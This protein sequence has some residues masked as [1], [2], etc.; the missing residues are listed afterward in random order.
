MLNELPL[1]VIGGLIITPVMI[2]TG[3]VLFKL[4]SDRAGGADIAGVTGLLTNPF[5]LLALFIYGLGTII[6]IYLL[7]SVPLS[8]AYPFM[9]LTFCLV[10]LMAWYFLG[11]PLTWRK[12]F[13]TAI[14][15]AGLVVIAS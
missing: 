10:P 6:W 12:G 14:I 15:M 8:F 5:L 11:E 3:Q 1:P 7:K 9:A 4:A 2:A 13:G